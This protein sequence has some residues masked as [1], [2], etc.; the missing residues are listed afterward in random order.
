MSDA[1]RARRTR[2]ETFGPFPTYRKALVDAISRRDKEDCFYDCRFSEED[3][4]KDW[5]RDGPPYCSNV[6]QS[7][8]AETDLTFDVVTQADCDQRAAREAALRQAGVARRAAA[9]E[10]KKAARG[11]EIAARGRVHYSIPPQPYDIKAECE[12]L[13]VG[14]LRDSFASAVGVGTAG[15][16]GG[17]AVGGGAEGEGVGG[18]GAVSTLMIDC[19]TTVNQ[20]GTGDTLPALLA[21]HSALRELHL[22]K[23]CLDE[24]HFFAILLEAP[25]LANTLR[26]LCF[27][28]SVVTPEAVESLQGFT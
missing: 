16:A 20:V 4:W 11:A 19:S 15:P 6:F 10:R 9:Y 24:E 13:S 7:G 25:H 14:D 23:S 3:I 2:V 8:D 26:T 22:H 5:R 18:V 1:E 12:I 27:Y 17:S 28:N 21:H